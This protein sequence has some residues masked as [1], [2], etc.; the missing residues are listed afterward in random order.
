[1]EKINDTEMKARFFAQYWGQIVALV[2][3]G[4]YTHPLGTMHVVNSHVITNTSSIAKHRYSLNLKP[5]S[6]ISD[7]DKIKIGEILQVYPENVLGWIN[8]EYVHEDFQDAF[9]FQFAIDY[10]RSKSYALPFM[11]YSVKEL[12]EL[13]WIK[14]TES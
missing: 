1:M 13:G 10:L 6:L 7:E 5:L 3:K 8:G 4:S 12:L 14:L 9:T 2:T 11:Q